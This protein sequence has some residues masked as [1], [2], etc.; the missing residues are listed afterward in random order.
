M[1]QEVACNKELFYET[2]YSVFK[3]IIIKLVNNIYAF[4]QIIKL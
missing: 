1:M 4:L 2:I 3:K